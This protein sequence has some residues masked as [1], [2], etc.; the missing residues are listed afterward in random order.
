MQASVRRHTDC[1]H[2][3]EETADYNP[4]PNE[5]LNVYVAA[6]DVQPFIGSHQDW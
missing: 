5:E 4:V 1:E 3:A 6:C 2:W